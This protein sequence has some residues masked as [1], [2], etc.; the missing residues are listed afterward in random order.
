MLLE[1]DTFPSTVMHARVPVYPLLVSNIEELCDKCLCP[2]HWTNPCSLEE[3][4]DK[5]DP[6]S[7]NTPLKEA[8]PV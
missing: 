5:E 7:S 1:G 8:V 6:L 2:Q 3:G 4:S